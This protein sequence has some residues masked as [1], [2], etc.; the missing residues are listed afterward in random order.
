VQI[1]ISIILKIG[2]KVGRFYRSLSPLIQNLAV[3]GKMS[4]KNLAVNG[5]IGLKNLAVNGNVPIFATKTNHYG[6]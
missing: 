2:C 5:K 3:N 4:L 6:K 1:K